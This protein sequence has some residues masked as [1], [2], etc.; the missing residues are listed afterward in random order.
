MNKGRLMKFTCCATTVLAFL[1]ATGYSAL[2]ALHAQTQDPPRASLASRV[3]PPANPALSCSPAPCVGSPVWPSTEGFTVNAPIAA[4]PVNPK[5][6]LLGSYTTNC[7]YPYGGGF[8]LS[9]DGGSTWGGLICMDLV[10]IGGIVYT[11]SSPPMVGFDHQDTAYLADFFV[12]I[13]DSSSAGFIA[14]EKSTDGGRNWTAPVPALGRPNSDTV[15]PS[16]AV[17]VGSSSPYLN[18]VYISAVVAGPIQDITKNQV[19]VSHSRDQGN[20]WKQVA[21]APVQTSPKVDFDTSLT[22]GKDGTVYVTW[23]YCNTGPSACGNLKGYMLFSKSTDGGD[24]WSAPVLMTT[25]DL[26]PELVLQNT[27]NFVTTIPVI[28]VDNSN[29]P[30]SGNLYVTLPNWTGSY[31]QVGV[32]HSTDGG[33]TW[34]KPV[35][36]APPSDT[37]DQFFPWLSVSPTGLVGVSWLDRRNDPANIEYQPFAAIS[38]DGG[39][40]F[41]PN[42][43]LSDA[44]SNP[45]VGT[46][47]GWMGDYIGNTW[48]GPNNFVAAWMDNSNSQYMVDAVGGIRLK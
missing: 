9:H 36:L 7:P 21:V 20:S 37:H 35:A 22:V 4:N 12:D 28:G 10:T 1:I 31:F 24:T 48:A 38:R 5:Q 43:L 39:Q 2:S 29:G 42:I 32:I 15:H 18:S 8:Y 30:Y 13:S 26:P 17:D 16:L 33:K 25:L 40:S 23:M 27:G 19:T 46:A 6:L 14:F 45:G 44:F 11:S 47:S 41:E 3:S 34:S